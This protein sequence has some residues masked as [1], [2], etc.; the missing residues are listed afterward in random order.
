[1]QTGNVTEQWSD[2]GSNSLSQLTCPLQKYLLPHLQL[3]HIAV[4]RGACASSQHLVEKL[5]SI[6]CVKLQ[7]VPCHKL[8]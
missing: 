1:M 2:S 7:A 3:K 4:L 6:F 5:P 8:S